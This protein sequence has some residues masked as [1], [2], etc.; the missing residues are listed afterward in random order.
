MDSQV[1]DDLTDPS[2]Q[3]RRAGPP[4]A[5]TCNS[6]RKTELHG[7][8]R[9]EP[10]HRYPCPCVKQHYMAPIRLDC[11]A[12]KPPVQR[13]SRAGRNGFLQ[14]YL[15]GCCR[16]QDRQRCVLFETI[17]H[18]WHSHRFTGSEKPDMANASALAV[19][20]TAEAM[21]INSSN[22]KGRSRSVG[23]CVDASMRCIGA[24]R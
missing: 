13:L 16:N 5:Q 9:L 7:A 8:P 17:S 11:P 22:T 10:N 18:E 24:E 1:R 6:N 15:S 2:P 21:C 23:R 14:A 4:H 20:P 12:K 3:R 19:A